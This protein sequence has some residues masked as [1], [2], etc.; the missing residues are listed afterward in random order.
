MLGDCEHGEPVLCDVDSNDF[1]V[2]DFD[3]DWDDEDWLF[4]VL[5][6]SILPDSDVFLCDGVVAIGDCF[7]C[8]GVVAVLMGVLELFVFFLM[9][10]PLDLPG[11]DLTNSMKLSSSSCFVLCLAICRN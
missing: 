6:T 3:D 2:N 8:E 10:V 9:D 1:G 11:R 4:G 5:S 7:C